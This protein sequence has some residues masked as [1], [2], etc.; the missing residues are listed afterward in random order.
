MTDGYDALIVNTPQELK[1][2]LVLA[3]KKVRYQLEVKH[4]TKQ[5]GI[6]VWGEMGIGKDEIM[7]EA[8]YEVYGND[9]FIIDLR[10]AGRE[11]VDVLGIPDL[12]Y[13]IRWKENKDSDYTKQQYLN[14]DLAVE[15]L[16]QL[17]ADR[18]SIGAGRT[19]FNP[20]FPD[21]AGRKGVI[22][23]GEL[24]LGAVAT[25]HAAYSWIYDRFVGDTHLPDTVQILANG[26]TRSSRAGV[27]EVPAPLLNRFRHIEIR[28]P[29]REYDNL[30]EWVESWTNYMI[31]RGGDPRVI[32]Y[33]NTYPDD[34]YL[35]DEKKVERAFATPR[36]WTFLSDDISGIE[37][38]DTLEQLSAMHIGTGLAHK[39]ASFVRFSQEFDLD[40]LYK[41]PEKTMGDFDKWEVSKKYAYV[42]AYSNDLLSKFHKATTDKEKDNI[43]K[44]YI[45]ILA[46]TPVEFKIL[47]IK[48]GS[49][50]KELRQKWI[51]S[52]YFTRKLGD[53]LKYIG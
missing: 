32:A 51:S 48:L 50:S 8:T 45:D 17:G 6:F 20:T 53:V 10:L 1:K 43:A 35:Y 23:F 15:L 4:N 9:A 30:V 31:A 52:Q 40:K 7:D 34:L 29:K 11:P 3:M 21:L 26:N 47:G 27:R 28:P 22:K 44:L 24:N 37:D 14:K 39:F 19:V 5:K 42:L 41:Y 16:R 13:L 46:L 33:I 2:V 49:T 36:T 25:Q 12:K 38:L 18:V